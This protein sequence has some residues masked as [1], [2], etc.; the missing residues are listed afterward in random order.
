[1]DN[2]E[3]IISEV[4]SVV[5]NLDQPDEQSSEN[6]G[7]IVGVYG[8]IDNLIDSANFTVST[9]VSTKKLNTTNL[10][11]IQYYIVYYEHCVCVE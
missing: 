5:G 3:D 2:V 1:L 4:A 10:M 6:L 11:Y 8:Q 7:I 9:N